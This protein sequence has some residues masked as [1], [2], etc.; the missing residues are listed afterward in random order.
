MC[1]I[2]TAYCT[3]Y[4]FLF[5]FMDTHVLAY[6]SYDGTILSFMP[7]T[8]HPKAIGECAMPQ[9]PIAQSKVGGPTN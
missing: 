9:L 1:L 8:S 6:L 4:L 5:I 7:A 2:H 3:L